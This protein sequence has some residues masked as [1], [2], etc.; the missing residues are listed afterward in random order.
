VRKS[1][2][3]AMSDKAYTLNTEPEIFVTRTLN[4]GGW[5]MLKTLLAKDRKL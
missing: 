4:L 2:N 5:N 3:F 1:D